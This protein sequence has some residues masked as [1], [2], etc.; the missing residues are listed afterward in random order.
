MAT[1][2]YHSWERSAMFQ[3]HGAIPIMIQTVQHTVLQ[4]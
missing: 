2:L 3:N 4:L 1:K